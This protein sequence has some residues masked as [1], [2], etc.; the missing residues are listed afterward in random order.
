M[1]D[2]W[3]FMQL[4]VG[5]ISVPFKVNYQGSISQIVRTSPN[6]R[7][8]LRYI[9]NIL[10]MASPTCK[11]EIRLVLFKHLRPG[12]N[13]IELLKQKILLNSC[14]LSELSRTP[15]TN[16]TCDMVVWLVTLFCC[17]KHLLAIDV[18]KNK[19]N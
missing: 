8:V 2:N 9:K 12:A 11:F 17:A 10:H 16:C 13:F 3:N 7:L 19:Y 6:L 15:V 14:L 5:R 18:F 4:G 1:G